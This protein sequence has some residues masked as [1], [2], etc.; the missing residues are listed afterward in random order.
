MSEPNDTALLSVASAMSDG[1]GIDWP[2]EAPASG[3]DT[4]VLQELRVLDQ[5]AAFHRA[6]ELPP[7]TVATTW[8]VPGA[9]NQRDDVTGARRIAC[10]SPGTIRIVR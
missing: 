6:P 5:I 7:S 1:A 8:K 2:E 9:P 10:P 4:K 3:Q